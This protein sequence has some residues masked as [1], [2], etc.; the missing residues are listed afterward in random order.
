MPPLADADLSRLVRLLDAPSGVAFVFL[1]SAALSLLAIGCARAPRPPRGALPLPE[2]VHR[3]AL[4]RAASGFAF[5]ALAA[6]ALLLAGAVT[7]AEGPPSVP[8]REGVMALAGVLALL[9]GLWA[10]QY[11]SA[12]AWAAQGRDAARHLGV[13][14]SIAAGI[15]FPLEVVF[16]ALVLGDAPLPLAIWA[17]FGAPFLGVVVAYTYA[18]LRRA[19][20]PDPVRAGAAA[21]AAPR[22]ASPA[23]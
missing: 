8:D 1:G 21:G 15:A 9:L 4:F 2:D 6:P 3:S 19:G 12:L 17:A 11:A 23:S 5:G 16:S 20:R 22:A 10:P 13:G 7:W 14:R 18:P